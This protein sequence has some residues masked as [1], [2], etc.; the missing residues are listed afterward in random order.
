MT[1]AAESAWF[2][3]QTQPNRESKASEHLRR[4][5]FEVYLPRYLKRRSHARKIETV[6]APLFPGYLFVAIDMATQRWRA[7]KSTI[8]VLRLVTNGDEP[9]PVS[10]AIINAMHQRE[11]EKGFVKIDQTR[12]FNR[13]DKV[14]VLAGAFTDTPGLFDGL[15]DRERVAILLDLLG[16]KVRVILD[17][18]LVVAA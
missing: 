17:A 18:D 1:S 14:R 16:R 8:G 7:I 11:D 9:A 3:V 15:A 5:G 4:Q 2:V 13:G 6:A 10:K 12:V